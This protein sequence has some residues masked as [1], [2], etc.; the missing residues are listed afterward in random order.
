MRALSKICM[1]V[2][3][4][5]MAVNVIAENVRISGKVVD[6]EDKPIEFATVRIAGTAVGTNTDL[7]G[8]YSLTVAPKDTIEV[9]FSCVGFKEIGRAHV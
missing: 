8:L 3:F 4:L 1:T 7:Q 9:V 6:G 5:A 2:I